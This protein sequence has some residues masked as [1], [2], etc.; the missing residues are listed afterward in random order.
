MTTPNPDINVTN[1]KEI[2]FRKLEARY[3]QQ[4]AQ[5]RSARLDAEKRVQEF[6]QKQTHADDDDDDPS[7]PYVEK[8]KLAK[9]L[10]RFGEQTKQ[11]TQSDIKQAVNEALAEERR[12]N[13]L[14]A[15]PDFQEVM[16]HADKF[17]MKDPELAD[18]IL[19][20][21]N[22]FER[23]KLVYKNIKAFGLHKPEEPKQS[24]QQKVDENKR[25]PFYHP[26]GV[27]TAPYSNAGDYSPNGQK[28]AYEKMKQLQQKVRM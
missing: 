4:L 25:S 17:A 11:Q 19:E 1:D 14:K 22:T 9:T 16:Q 26:S 6:S 24:I 10:N 13:W 5:E 7:E 15:N 23:Q 28:Q 12:T 27:G 21:P 8:K 2:N 18:S 3:E 20:M